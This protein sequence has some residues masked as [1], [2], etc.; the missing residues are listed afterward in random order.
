MEFGKVELEQVTKTDFT[1]PKSHIDNEYILSNASNKTIQFYLGCSSW[2]NADWKGHIY[3]KGTKNGDFLHFYAQSF[4]CVELNATHYRVFDRATIERWVSMVPSGF[5]FFPKFTNIISH[6]EKLVN[7]K[8]HTQ[9]FYEQIMT[10][11]EHG[12]PAF[13][14][15]H[16]DFSPQYFPRLEMYLSTLPKAYPV[17]LEVRHPKWF[18]NEVDQQ[19]LFDLCRQFNIG[20]VCTDTAGRRDVVHT[21]LSI[22]KVFIRFV[23]NG[24]HS[25][26]YERIDSW[27]NQLNVWINQGL[28][29]VNFIVHQENEV[30]ALQLCDYIQKEIKKKV[31]LSLPHI[32]F[33]EQQGTLNF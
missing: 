22:P 1:L 2:G 20:I 6:Y 12:G 16:N 18:E 23:G 4:N 31:N 8:S 30:H 17:F 27:I 32:K 25:S 24:L 29:E 11:G 13:L 10:L 9:R 33:I 15:L 3:P 5:K 19:K 21:R 26:D 7:C 28:H 14:Q